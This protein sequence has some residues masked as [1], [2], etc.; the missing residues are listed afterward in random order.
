LIIEWIK[1]LSDEVGYKFKIA[2]ATLIF[3]NVW[4]LV[5]DIDTNLALEIESISMQN[6]QHP[7]NKDYVSDEFE[8]DWNI[9][10]QQGE[11]SFKS[12]GFELYIRKSPEIKQEQSLGLE[13]RGG[14]SFSNEIV[15]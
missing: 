7:K 13:E 5:F 10:L 14:I 15:D 12:I 9:F 3:R 6:P 2:P 8:Y 1:P 11:I 4:K